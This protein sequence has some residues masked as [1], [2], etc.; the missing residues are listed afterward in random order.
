MD[1]LTASSGCENAHVSLRVR[2]HGGLL[3]TT[4]VLA[5]SLCVCVCGCVC[6][7]VCVVGG[8]VRGGVCVCV[9]LIYAIKEHCSNFSS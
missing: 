4:G 6:G 9:C 5:Y 8:W 2:A 1:L 3:L 7:G